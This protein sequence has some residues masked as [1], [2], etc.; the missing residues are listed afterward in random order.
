[1]VGVL[2]SID[3]K[4]ITLAMEVGEDKECRMTFSVPIGMVNRVFDIAA[5]RA[6]DAE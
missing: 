4:A 1:M 6:F 2:K 5:V 3:E